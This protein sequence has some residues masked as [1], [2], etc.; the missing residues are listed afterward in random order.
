MA[1]EWTHSMC[2]ICWLVVVEKEGEPEREPVRLKG[3]FL[4]EGVCCWCGDT[5][6]SGIYRREHPITLKCQGV[7]KETENV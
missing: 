2:D 1:S 7:H 5:H 4:R 3:E 6:M